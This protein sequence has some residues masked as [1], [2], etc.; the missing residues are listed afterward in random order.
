MTSADLIPA[1]TPGLPAPTLDLLGRAQ[2]FAAAAKSEGTRRAYASD[3]AHFSDWC[4]A[5]GFD[6]LPAL[7][8]TVGLYLTDHAASLK[9][10]TLDRRLAAISVQH[11]AAGHRLDTRHPAI[12][13]VL[14]GIR[15]T[16]GSA[17]D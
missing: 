17:P 10:T 3:W 14:S 2:D 16:K 13:D 8:A 6:A 5:Q 15:R 1:P 11:R 12:R 9:V 4:A 7:P